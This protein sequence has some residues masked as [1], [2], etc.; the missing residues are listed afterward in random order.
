MKKTMDIKFINY[1]RRKEMKNLILGLMAGLLLIGANAF[2]ADGDL[3]VNGKIGIGT[4]D[5]QDRLDVYG[6]G[7]NILSVVDSASKLG[8]W[9]GHNGTRG[10]IRTTYW[11]G[12]SNIFSPLTFQTNNV[13]RL[14]ITASGFVGIGTTSP[15]GHLQIESADAGT[16]LRMANTSSGGRT[17]IFYSQG[18]SGNLHIWDE[19]APTTRLLIQG[20]TGYVGI[21]TASPSYTLHV[22]G[23]A[24]S[25][26]GWSGSDIRWKKN[27]NPIE[28]ALESVLTLQGVNYEW[29]VDEYKDKNF[30]E[31]RQIGLIAQDVEKTLS[32]LVRTDN[33]GYKAISYEK[34]T[35]VLVEA[36]KEQQ[37]KIA[38]LEDK[39]N[40]LEKNRK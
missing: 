27:I 24:Y 12:G 26:G 15:G 18:G 31:G 5:P 25:S 21:G 6:S 3:I 13:D 40:T 1:R 38:E 17:W 32:E 39:I 35:A 16:Q 28:N 36:I 22:N 30:E 4:T 11:P 20:G 14:Y 29:R 2:A 37:K 34:L 33:E 7:D 23:S 10:I 9:I 19:G 8:V